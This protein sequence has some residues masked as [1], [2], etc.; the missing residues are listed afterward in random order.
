[1]TKP[2][3]NQHELDHSAW[4]RRVVSKHP[5]RRGILAIL[6]CLV[7]EYLVLP[8][9]AGMGKSLHL[10]RHANIPLVALGIFLEVASLAS[11]AKLTEA[12][13]P[14]R[15]IS[16]SRIWR[17][18]M[19]TLAISHVIPG[20]TAS[21]EGLGFH[22]LTNEGVSG[23]DVGFALAIGGIGSA[24]VLN[25]LLWL[26]LIVSIPMSGFNPLYTTAAI[27]GALLLA[28]FISIV[29]LVTKGEDRAAVAL[30]G[31]VLRLP[32]VRD[33]AA[34]ASYRLVH[35]VADKTRA[36]ANNRSLLRRA[37]LWAAADLLFDATSLFVFLAAF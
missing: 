15:A 35:Q 8:Q 24:L 14:K 21:G 20:G 18:E 36:L 10:L 12:V 30:K 29:L 25:A 32:F 2:S 33:S 1:M 17:I 6:F 27:I 13:L 26:A 7:V 31:L 11:Y 5:Y 16:L 9:I 3:S 23:S 22:L 28:A 34:E 19:S 37:L 4:W